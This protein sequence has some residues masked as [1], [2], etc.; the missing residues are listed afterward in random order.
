MIFRLRD[1][2]LRLKLLS[3]EISDLHQHPHSTYTTTHTDLT[4][5]PHVA[6]II[7]HPIA[8]HNTFAEGSDDGLF[9]EFTGLK[10]KEVNKGQAGI[11]H[12]A[13]S[14][15]EQV[16]GAGNAPVV[17]AFFAQGMPI[18]P[19]VLQWLARPTNSQRV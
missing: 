5:F 16:S 2:E 12:I 19:A 6:C 1:L 4:A 15:R 11:I 14:D 10:I 18:E 9:D 8:K 3:S 7:R 13:Q 17:P